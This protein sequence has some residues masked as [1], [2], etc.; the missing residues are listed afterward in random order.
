ML[1]GLSS[2]AY[3]V[4]D[5]MLIADT[6]EMLLLLLLRHIQHYG[7]FSASAPSTTLPT[8]STLSN[9]HLGVS[10]STNPT[11][12]AMRLLAAPDPGAFKE[13]LSK[14]LGPILS[15]LEALESV[16]PLT[17]PSISRTTA[18]GCLL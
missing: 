7:L 6:T 15:K 5:L 1:L 18:Q 16:S 12:T 8:S 2:L 3:V 17:D 9:S 10:K 13:D 11:N 14:K 4:P